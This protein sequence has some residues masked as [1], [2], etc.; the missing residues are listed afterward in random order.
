MRLGWPKDGPY[1]LCGEINKQKHPYLDLCYPKPD[2]LV[3]VPGL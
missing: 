2:L 1:F 3:R